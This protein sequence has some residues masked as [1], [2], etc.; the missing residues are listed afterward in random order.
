MSSQKKEKTTKEDSKTKSLL[1]K[2]QIYNNK[3]R[4]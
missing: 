2:N 3:E 1:Y 4:E